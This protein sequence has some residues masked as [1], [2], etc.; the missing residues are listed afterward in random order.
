MKTYSKPILNIFTFFILLFI[1]IS[2]GFTLS[3]VEAESLGSPLYESRD[4][5]WAKRMGGTAFDYGKDIA[6][7]SNGNV[8]T[9][10][11]FSYT[12]DFNPG[13]GTSNLTSVGTADIFLSKLDSDGKF[14]W[15]KNMGS[16]LNMSEGNGIAVDSNRQCFITGAISGVTRMFDL[17]KMYLT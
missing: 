2:T 10:G 9:T 3:A 12:A 13:P 7:D 14:I 15:E 8:Y 6:V 11:A 1:V 4:F 17:V 5:F 16:A